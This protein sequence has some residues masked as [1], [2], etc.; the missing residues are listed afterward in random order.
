MSIVLPNG[1]T[2][3]PKTAEGFRLICERVHN[4]QPI[5]IKAT[6]GGVTTK[7]VLWSPDD[8]VRPL[9]QPYQGPREERQYQAPRVSWLRKVLGAW[10]RFRVSKGT[11]SS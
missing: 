11:P 7:H 8:P 5:V 1:S 10:C 3:R 9:P 4:R 6:V 2:I